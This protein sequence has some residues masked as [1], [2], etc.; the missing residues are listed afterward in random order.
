MRVAALARATLRGYENYVYQ[1]DQGLFEESE[2][3]GI[4]EN[5]RR[6]MSFAMFREEWKL[7]RDE[8]SD[9]LRPI[10]DSL[11]AQAEQAP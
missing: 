4:L 9:R 11:A 7:T 5:M 2:W 8:Y 3:R 6:G 1:R 10:M